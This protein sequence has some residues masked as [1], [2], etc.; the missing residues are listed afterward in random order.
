MLNT[1]IKLNAA[2]KYIVNNCSNISCW[3]VVRDTFMKLMNSVKYVLVQELCG[4]LI[5]EKINVFY[6]KRNFKL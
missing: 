5:I 4:E 6:L 2:V 3:E 1:Y